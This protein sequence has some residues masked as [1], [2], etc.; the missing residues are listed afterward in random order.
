MN[1]HILPAL[2]AFK[3]P[4]KYF[5]FSVHLKGSVDV[6]K[7][8]FI[9]AILIMEYQYVFVLTVNFNPSVMSMV[10]YPLILPSMRF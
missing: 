3:C 8:K 7:T 4:L 9:I 5:D 6:V 10:L 2:P 1:L